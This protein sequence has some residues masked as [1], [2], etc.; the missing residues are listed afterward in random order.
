MEKKETERVSRRLRKQVE[1]SEA[2]IT[3][4]EGELAAMDARLASGDTGIVNDSAFYSLYE[5]KKQQL[6]TLMH[7]WEKAH[8]ELEG[9]EKEY[10]NNDDN[11]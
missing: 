6:E 5:N 4:V 10:I 3:A 9:F 8:N 2:K 11:I 1:E 7:Q